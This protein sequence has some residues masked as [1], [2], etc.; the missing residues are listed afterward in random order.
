M[1][2]KQGTWIVA[3]L[4]AVTL[5]SCQQPGPEGRATAVGVN[6]VECDPDDGGLQLPDGFCALVVAD[7]LGR[8]RHLTVADNG[9]IYVKLRDADNGGIVALRDTTGDGRGLR[10][11][12]HP[13]SQR[14]PVC[15]LRH[16]RRSLPT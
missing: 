1:M 11:H 15:L 16:A 2:F 3:A 7:D 9:D 8:G 5:L 6:G 13:D 10:W 12:G 14:L 4:A